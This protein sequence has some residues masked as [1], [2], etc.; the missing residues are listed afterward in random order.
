MGKPPGLKTQTKGV[1]FQDKSGENLRRWLNVDADMFY[2]SK[3][4]A[5]LP[6]DFYFP[7][8]GKTGDLPP[9]IAFADKWHPQIIAQM[10][11]IKL[12]I[13]IGR[14]A[15]KYYLKQQCKKNLSETIKAY[16]NYLPNYF[17]LAHPSPLNFRWLHNNPYFQSEVL[18]CLQKI[19]KEILHS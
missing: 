15:Q 3:Q 5:V 14:Y 11:H 16:K 7:G 19:V 13:L 8:K 17:V 9:R 4:I 6:L 18:P 12:I 1:V 10:P 2:H